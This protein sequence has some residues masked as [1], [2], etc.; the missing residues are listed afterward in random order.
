[1]VSM[2]VSGKHGG[3]VVFYQ[4]K[5]TIGLYDEFKENKSSNK[6]KNK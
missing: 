2:L 5:S 6:N 4:T 3:G 1:M